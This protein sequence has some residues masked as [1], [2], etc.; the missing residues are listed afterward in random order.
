MNFAAAYLDQQIRNWETEGT[1]SVDGEVKRVNYSRIARENERL[2]KMLSSDA[3]D[4]AVVNASAGVGGK[5]N[6]SGVQ[7]DAGDDEE[8]LWNVPVQS[9]A[10]DTKSGKGSGNKLGGFWVTYGSGAT[11]RARSGE[12][13]RREPWQGRD[14]Y[15]GLM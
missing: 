14:P 5:G 8:D 2:R 9:A 6:L 3:T 10:Q 1:D 7:S 13:D 12:R 15:G 11:P 4:Y